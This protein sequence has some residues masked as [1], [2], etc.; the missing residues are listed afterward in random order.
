LENRIILEF[1]NYSSFV[2][3]FTSFDL[4]TFHL[5]KTKLPRQAEIKEIPET[6]KSF[7]RNISGF[8]AKSTLKQRRLRTGPIIQSPHFQDIL[9]QTNPKRPP[10]KKLMMSCGPGKYSIPA[11]IEVLSRQEQQGGKAIFDYRYSFNVKV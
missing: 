9:G 2:S 8:P 3:L 1:F 5:E 11:L 10:I 6:G 7:S 4:L